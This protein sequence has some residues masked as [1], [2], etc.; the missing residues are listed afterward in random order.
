MEYKEIISDN[1]YHKFTDTEY[2]IGAFNFIEK[3]SN[4]KKFKEYYCL[5]GCFHR[6]GGPAVI[7]YD[8]NGEIEREHYRSNG[9]PHRE[10]GPAEIWY[11]S[12]VAN[13]SYDVGGERHEQYYLNGNRYS[14]EDYYQQIKLKLYW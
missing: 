10:D 9:L 14:E 1:I 2:Q 6:D 8:R 12:N 5:N 13:Y 11:K 3:H 4:G 7:Y